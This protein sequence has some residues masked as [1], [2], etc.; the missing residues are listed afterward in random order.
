MQNVP[1]KAHRGDTFDFYQYRASEV[2]EF[3]NHKYL[4]TTIEINWRM[5]E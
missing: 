3:N 1:Y 5:L 2:S 4:Y